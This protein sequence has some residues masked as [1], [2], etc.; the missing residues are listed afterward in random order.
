MPAWTLLDKLKQRSSRMK[1]RWVAFDRD[2]AAVYG[3]SRKNVRQA[4]TRNSDRFPSDTLFKSTQGD[5]LLTE[6]A[7]LLLAGILKSPQAIQTSVDVIREVF[8]AARN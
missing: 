7:I 4:L 8:G 6:E 1:G 3:V 5:F 2:V